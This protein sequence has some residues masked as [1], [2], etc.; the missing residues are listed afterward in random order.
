MKKFECSVQRKPLLFA[1]KKGTI[2]TPSEKGREVIGST[3]N[4]TSA[5]F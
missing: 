5:D 2:R 3:R 4:L 1:K